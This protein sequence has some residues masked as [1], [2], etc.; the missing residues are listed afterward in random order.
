MNPLVLKKEKTVYATTHWFRGGGG[1]AGSAIDWGKKDEPL[2]L[3][4]NQPSQS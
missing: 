2:V 1:K 4:N 3:K